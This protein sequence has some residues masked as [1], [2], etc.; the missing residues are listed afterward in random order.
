MKDRDKFFWMMFVALVMRMNLLTVQVLAFTIT[1]VHTRRTLVWP[2]LV[3]QDETESRYHPRMK[4][5]LERGAWGFENFVFT[6]GGGHE[7]ILSSHSLILLLC[8]LNHWR[9]GGGNN[10]WLIVLNLRVC[11]CLCTTYVHTF[12]HNCIELPRPTG[13]RDFY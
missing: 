10:T 11:Y 13:G 12:R 1:T 9:L 5:W 2:A 8:I 7:G 3:S 4:M 6:G